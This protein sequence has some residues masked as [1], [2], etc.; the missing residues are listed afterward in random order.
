MFRR[1]LRWCVIALF[2]MGAASGIR[3]EAQTKTILFV[4]NSFTY[5]AY[6]PVRRYRAETVKDLNGT[7][8]GGVPALFKRFCDQAGRDYTVSLET[9]GGKGLEW[10]EAEKRSLID[11]AWDVVILQGLSVLDRRKPGNPAIHVAAADRLAKMF[12]RANGKVDVQLVATWARADLVYRPGSPWSGK[13]LSMMTRDLRAAS[14]QAKAGSPEIDAIVPVGQAWLQ[15]IDSGVADADPYD[16]VA[17]G[18]INLWTYDQYHGSAE[19]YYLSALVIFGQITG[20]DPRSLG[21]KEKSADD[22]G[23]AP[24]VAA[25]LQ[26]IAYTLTKQPTPV[27][28]QTIPLDGFRGARPL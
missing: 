8:I 24:N 4:G 11:R 12:T 22:L 14:D 17:F 27:V 26:S 23:I 5:G 21:S 15:A 2:S 13:P 3:A 25:A 19:G 1:F 6:S 18:K 10:H 20:V 16:G 28:R 9:D 7:G